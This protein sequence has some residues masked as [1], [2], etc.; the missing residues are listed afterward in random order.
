MSVVDDIAWFVFSV[1]DE[2]GSGVTL[3]A[4]L[5]SSAPSSTSVMVS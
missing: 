1:P 3:S 5:G 4:T 2:D